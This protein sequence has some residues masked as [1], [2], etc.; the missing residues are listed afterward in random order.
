[1]FKLKEFVMWGFLVLA[2]LGLVYAKGHS[3]ATDSLT[4]EHQAQQLAAARQLEVERDTTQRALADLSK[5][6]QAYI[7]TSKASA[8]RTIADLR[9]NGIRLSVALADSTVRCVTGDGRSLADGRAELRED[10]S[11]FL[12]GEA[13]RADAQVKALQGTIKTLQ[14]G[15]P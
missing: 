7:A 6:W 4:L 15:T 11:Q 2:G 1:M 9:G 13:Q 14:G 12:I 10:V 3:D 5:E 8:D